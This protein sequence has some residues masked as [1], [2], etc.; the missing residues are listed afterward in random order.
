MYILKRYGSNKNMGINQDI[1][2]EFVWD[3]AKDANGNFTEWYTLNCEERS[4][5]QETVLSRDEGIKVF[6]KMFNK[7][8]DKS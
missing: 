5:Y 4:A 2:F 6:E 8:V 1:Q 3:N 7:T